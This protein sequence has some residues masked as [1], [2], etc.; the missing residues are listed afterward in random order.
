M[1]LLRSA[2]EGSVPGLSLLCVDGHFHVHLEFSLYACPSPIF[3]FYK[4]FVG[5]HSKALRVRET[6]I[7]STHTF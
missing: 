6:S 5:S 1:A 2:R 4:L 3:L 7:Y